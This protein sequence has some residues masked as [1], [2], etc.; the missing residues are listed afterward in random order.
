MLMQVMLIMLLK[1]SNATWPRV[2]TNRSCCFAFWF[3]SVFVF[4]DFGRFF[5]F[6]GFWCPKVVTCFVQC[7]LAM[8]FFWFSDLLTFFVGSRV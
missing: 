2:W 7:L 8:S 6:D 5:V 1:C 3:L 4:D